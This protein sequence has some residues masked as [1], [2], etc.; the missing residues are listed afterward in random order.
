MSLQFNRFTRLQNSRFLTYKCGFTLLEILIAMA[1]SGIALIVLLQIFSSNMK[2][3]SVS[4]DYVSAI[5]TAEAK[6]REIL[7]KDDLSEAVW[8]DTT[9]DG[10]RISVSIKEAQKDRTQNLKVKF[11]EVNLTIYW[12][13]AAKER[14]LTLRTAKTVN[15]QV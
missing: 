9:P 3:I 10:Y 12:T 7:D 15:K 11:L 2:A 14:S 1:I 5:L 8:K 13:K 6:M 4:E